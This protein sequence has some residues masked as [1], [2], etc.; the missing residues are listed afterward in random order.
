M[1]SQKSSLVSRC[2]PNQKK[3]ILYDHKSGGPLFVLAGA[4]SGKTYVLTSRIVYLILTGVK[5][6]SLL[7]LTF[8]EAAAAEMS[9]RAAGKLKELGYCTS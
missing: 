4:G 8:T 1:P 5:P 2:N 6:S 3:A 7:A 9:E